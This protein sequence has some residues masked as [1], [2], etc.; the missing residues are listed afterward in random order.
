M[1]K[2]ECGM[3]ENRNGGY[4]LPYDIAIIIQLSRW[5]GVRVRGHIRA[6]KTIAWFMYGVKP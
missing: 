6:V 3:I 1:E 2:Q 5:L 4:L